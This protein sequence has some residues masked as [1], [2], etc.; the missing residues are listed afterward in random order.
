MRRWLILL[1]VLM[2]V[3]L[4]AWA[5]GRTLDARHHTQTRIREI[6]VKL[7]ALSKEASTVTDVSRRRQAIKEMEKLRREAQTLQSELGQWKSSSLFGRFRELF[8]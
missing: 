7:K 6:N 3:G 2:A 4:T 5:A 1:V 8:N